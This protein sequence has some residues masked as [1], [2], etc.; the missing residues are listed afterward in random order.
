MYRPPGRENHSHGGTNT[1]TGKF[2]CHSV[3]ACEHMIFFFESRH[4][5]SAP[6]TAGTQAVGVQ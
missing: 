3:E 4:T 5:A 2:V 6:G 1:F